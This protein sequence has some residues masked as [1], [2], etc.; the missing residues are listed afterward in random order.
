MGKLGDEPSEDRKT[1]GPSSRKSVRGVSGENYEGFIEMNLVKE[2]HEYKQEGDTIYIHGKITIEKATLLNR[3]RWRW[4]QF[5]VRW[6]KAKPPQ[7][8]F[9][10][11]SKVEN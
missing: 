8:F 3:M 1:C 11:D 2:N 5:K 7:I 9:E 4:I 6:L 10:D